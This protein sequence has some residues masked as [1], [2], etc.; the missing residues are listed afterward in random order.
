ML[1]SCS[2]EFA[3]TVVGEWFELFEWKKNRLMARKMM[4]ILLKFDEEIVRECLHEFTMT[5]RTN[6]IPRLQEIEAVLNKKKTDRVVQNRSQNMLADLKATEN[7]N[8][9]DAKYSLS[10][11]LKM[12]IGGIDEMNNNRLTRQQ[13]YLNQAQFF[14]EKGRHQDAKELKEKA[15]QYA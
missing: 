9:V 2:T 3:K 11:Y 12:V 8:N 5:F 4:N 15:E 10:T 13:F 14:E 1:M 6:F 7:N